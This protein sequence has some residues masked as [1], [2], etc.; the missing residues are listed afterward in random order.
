MPAAAH[1]E[2]ATGHRGA[3]VAELAVEE[4]QV[5]AA[6]GA[7]H[8]AATWKQE[9]AAAVSQPRGVQQGAVAGVLPVVEG[10]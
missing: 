5:G 6:V 9:A 2:G 4:L 7:G 10:L 8:C 3:V 1:A